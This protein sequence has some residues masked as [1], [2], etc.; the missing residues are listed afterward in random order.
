MT[1]AVLS[2]AVLVAAREP[3]GAGSLALLVVVLLAVAT[4]LLYRSMK[5]QLSKVPKTFDRPEDPAARSPDAP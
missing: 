4:L 3:S 1:T 5:K 2:A